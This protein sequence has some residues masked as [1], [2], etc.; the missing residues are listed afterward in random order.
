M[1]PR[2]HRRLTNQQ[3]D[4]MIR[5]E[6]RRIGLLDARLRSLGTTDERLAELDREAATGPLA[7]GDILGLPDGDYQLSEYTDHGTCLLDKV[8]TSK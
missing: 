5:L 3:L 8:N 4:A 6:T 2:R 7:L 1:R